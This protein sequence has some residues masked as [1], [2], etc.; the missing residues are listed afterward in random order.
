MVVREAAH[1]GAQL[2]QQILHFVAERPRSVETVELGGLV[3]DLEGILE[4]VVGPRI[5]VTV[6]RPDDSWPVQADQTHVEQILL[7]LASNARDAMPGG[8]TLTVGI[9][10]VK[11]EERLKAERATL[12][13]GRFVRVSVRDTGT[14]MTPEVR[15]RAFEPF[16]S[17]KGEEEDRSGGFGLST[18]RRLVRGYGG[19][20]RVD[21]EKGRGSEFQVYLPV[22]EEETDGSI[23]REVATGRIQEPR[24]GGARVLL[25]DADPDVR[26]VVQRV[27]ERDGHSVVAVGTVREGLQAFDRVRPVFDVLVT[28]VILPDRSGHDLW[29]AATRR[30]E[31]LP[32]IFMSALDRET[33]AAEGVSEGDVQ[34]VPKPLDP[35]SLRE[36]VRS[37]VAEEEETDRYE[38]GEV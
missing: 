10:N 1:R 31:S 28:D 22:R 11:L 3:D 37:I 32:V 36:A 5:R 18:V 7:N 8:G 20:I 13:P 38:T 23:R 16:F 9:E 25:V 24:P 17:T 35:R 30:V 4:K 29:R 19:G 27:L 26:K 14:G 2:V 34:V 15:E 6:E 21:S 33:A 12:R